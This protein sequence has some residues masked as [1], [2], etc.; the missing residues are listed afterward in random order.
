[1]KLKEK[2][3]E[4]RNAN[5]F[6][7]VDE[8]HILELHIGLDGNGRK[9]IELR[10]CFSPRTVHGTSAIDVNQYKKQE[11]NTLRFSLRDEEE[12]GLFYKFCEDIIEQ[13]RPLKEEKEGYN[14][15]LNRFS[16]WKKLFKSGKGKMLSESEIMGL[17][18]EILFLKE[19]LSKKIGLQKAL[20]SWSGQ[21]LTHK[22]FSCGD[23]WYE[24]K[25]ISSGQ[26]NIKIASLE[27]L[28]SDNDG[29]LVVHI[30]E[31]MSTAYNGIT[32]NKLVLDTREEFI[33]DDDR[34]K[35]MTKV[36]LQKYEYNN[37][38]D[39]FVYEISDFRRYTVNKNF[40]KLTRENI[41]AAIRKATY[42]ISLKDIAGFEIK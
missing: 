19:H 1:M 18:G 36:A 37:Y 3:E 27:Q 32:L 5:Y 9:A 40:P 39:E 31:K 13:T 6:T 4:F 29:E 41:S 20:E 8:T 17:I 26:P 33:S 15:V 11:Y 16:Q 21:E 12:S 30:L 22:D 14:A 10:S 2:F 38:Y 35:F 25:A 42:E 28:E 24:S 34:D 23:T 7:R